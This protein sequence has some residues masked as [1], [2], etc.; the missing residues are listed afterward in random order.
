MEDKNLDYSNNALQNQLH[1][2]SQKR[3]EKYQADTS[4]EIFPP[5]SSNNN[6]SFNYALNHE[7]KQ[8]YQPNESKYKLNQVHQQS[9]QKNNH[10]SSNSNKT[11]PSHPIV[12]SPLQ[13]Q[14]ENIQHQLQFQRQ[15]HSQNNSQNLQDSHP[16]SQGHINRE[17][18]TIQQDGQYYY[19]ERGQLQ[20]IPYDGYNNN[21]QINISNN[22]NNNQN[23]N[24]IH[25]QNNIDYDAQQQQQMFQF[26]QQQQLNRQNNQ[27]YPNQVPPEVQAEL[28]AQQIENQRLKKRLC[29]NFV[30]GLEG[31]TNKQKFII[32]VYSLLF[33]MLG[34]TF[35]FTLIT[36][37]IPSLQ[38]FMR[39]E[40]GLY[41]AC[42]AI[43]IALALG[44][45]CLNKVARKVPI[46]YICLGLYTLFNT[47][48]IA[49]ISS[50]QD[51]ELVL[52][53]TALTFGIFF[54]L[55]VLT[56]FVTN[57]KFIIQPFRPRQNYQCFQGY[58]S[59]FAT[60]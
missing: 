23:E 43:T 37:C 38:E 34:V 25:Q 47:Y 46:N 36:L 58:P 17:H 2:N 21:S 13:Q 24:Y 55:T 52:I 39:R 7:D 32:K 22:R 6:N 33:M 53:A 57:F 30:P 8:G 41:W 49:A 16:N 11:V 1:Q 40:R 60:S 20:F 35:G 50:W 29:L 59:Y 15:Q 19:D 27:Q 28:E 44:I 54:G 56:F 42:V 4:I 10:H 51:P 45:F 26:Y 14:H 3:L 5:I 48:T 18:S 31:K 9:K 12:L